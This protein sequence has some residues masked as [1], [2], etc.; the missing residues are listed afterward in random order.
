MC[1]IAGWYR[2]DARPVW[3]EDVRR[4]CDAI[5][6]R[7]PDGSGVLVDRDFGF[8]MRRLS[9]LDIPDGGQPMTTPDGRLSLVYNGEVYNH[10]ELRR[11]L[12]AAGHVFRTRSDTETVLAAFAEWGDDAWRRLEGMFAAAIWDRSA[13]RLTLARDHLGIKPLFY[14]EQNSGLS[15]ASELKALRAL[16]LHA[17]DIDE[18]AVHD[19]FRF[20]NVRRPR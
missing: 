12:E 6:H 14:S 20:G 1:G 9:I 13:R 18:R 5:R 4:Q 2:R 11:E 16:P 3:K 7:G 10:P 15:F 19:F 17:F 8:G